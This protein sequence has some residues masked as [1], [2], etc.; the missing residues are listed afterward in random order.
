M[1][2]YFSDTCNVLCRIGGT[3][4][5][6]FPHQCLRRNSLPPNVYAELASTRPDFVLPDAESNKRFDI[7]AVELLKH[8][9]LPPIWRDFVEYHTSQDFYFQILDLFEQDFIS[10]YPH[11]K[12]KMRG[13]K[14]GRRFDGSDSDIFLDCQLSINTPVKVRGTVAPPHVDNPLSLWAS[15][16]YMKE[17]DDDAGGD[18]VLH[19]C[20]RAPVFH[21]KRNCYPECVRPWVTIPYAA[22]TYVC[23]INSPISVHS[24]T[25]REVTDKQRLMVNITL[26]FGRPE[27]QLF[28]LVER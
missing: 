14:V 11:L 2:K 3:E 28:S 25:E 17:A 18:F 15:L 22:N 5:L 26:E 6:P 13:F 4:E 23:F 16:L 24:V 12:D 27:Q 21:G 7:G 9:N 8:D 19:K 10:F 1:T 20:V